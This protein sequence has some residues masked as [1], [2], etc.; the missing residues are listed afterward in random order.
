MNDN[1]KI[2]SALKEKKNHFHLWDS[3]KRVLSIV[4]ILASLLL[5]YLFISLTIQPEVNKTF[6]WFD[7]LDYP[8]ISN[9]SYGKIL[10][11]PEANY[12]TAFS[13]TECRFGF[14]L[15]E[16]ETEIRVLTRDLFDLTFEKHTQG[17]DGLPEV[18]FLPLDLN[19]ESS[20]YVDLL[21]LNR[22]Q[23]GEEFWPRLSKKGQAFVLAWAT[24]KNGNTTI[25]HSLCRKIT[26]LSRFWEKNPSLL[27]VVQEEIGEAEI[28]RIILLFG[29]TSIERI[30]LLNQF[31]RFQKRF[32]MSKYRL[33]ARESEQILNQMVA[34]DDAH[35]AT[36]EDQWE[37]LTNEAK[38]KELIF[39]LRDQNGFQYSQPGSADIFNDSRKEMSPAARLVDLEYDA[40]PYLID[41]LDDFRF[42]RTV[43]YHRDY[44][45]SHH[46]L[47]IADCALT[48]LEIIAARSFYEGSY[49]DYIAMNG[50]LS[51]GCMGSI[52]EEK[53]IKTEAKIASTRDKVQIWWDEFQ[54]KG[55]KQT[56]IDG[57]LQADNNSLWQAS[58][59]IQKY[60][61]CFPVLLDT[62]N[63]TNNEWL[64]TEIMNLIVD[65]DNGP[66]ALFLLEQL[67]NNP[68]YTI[69]VQSASIL[70]KRGHPEPLQQMLSEF[71][72]LRDP[73]RV[74]YFKKLN[75]ANKDDLSYGMLSP[76]EQASYDWFWARQSVA[77]F[78]LESGESQAIRTVRKSLVY[79]DAS[80]RMDLLDYVDDLLRRMFEGLGSTCDISNGNLTDIA[81]C[82]EHFLV[83]CLNDVRVPGL[84]SGYQ[85]GKE[86]D[87]P[88]VCDMAAFYLWAHWK[89]K[90]LFDIEA[91]QTIRD[92]QIKKCVEIWQSNPNT[93]IQ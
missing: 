65:I 55:E 53:Q 92:E 47:R 73:N 85:H 4:I 39:L 79:F 1:E 87:D 81:I 74:E 33:L 68:N 49:V 84:R 42:T 45:F 59:L 22:G 93:I 12:Q 63:K 37:K 35:I 51:D 10:V 23:D 17:S 75:K 31:I 27:E 7:S 86:Y 29:D 2:H 57:T 8:D 43:A 15:H 19:V 50:K 83:S 71:I 58:R 32:P 41:S 28:W 62:F 34:E 5:L 90:Y 82:L 30:E 48:I 77:K 56:L 76:E 44:Y 18:S 80:A 25:S 89:N 70:H 61:E 88:R 54:R 21:D 60:P 20:R 14:L 9:C 24:F 46:V 36:T 13:I 64:K 38:V 16:T 26:P 3:I 6:K 40:V 67:K 52:D 91:S 11:Q 72:T 66:I 69:R 78:L